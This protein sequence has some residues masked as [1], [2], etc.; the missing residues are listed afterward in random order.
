[1]K[2]PDL[3][4]LA[5]PHDAFKGTPRPAKSPAMPS[6]QNAFGKLLRFVAFTKEKHGNLTYI[7]AIICIKKYKLYKD[8][9]FATLQF[10]ADV[11]Y[12]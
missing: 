11:L 9:T 12:T 7:T 1:M 5:K 8:L 6:K 4:R 10:A 3:L 2:K